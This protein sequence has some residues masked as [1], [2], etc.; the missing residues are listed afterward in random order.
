M[1]NLTPSTE[2][3]GGTPA[4]FRGGKRVFEADT[5]RPVVEAVAAGEVE[6]HAFARRGYPGTRLRKGELEGICTLGYFDAKGR[7]HWGLPFHRN[8]G[9]EFT[10]MLSGEMPMGVNRFRGILKPGHIMITRPWQPHKLGNPCF[11]PGRLLWLIIDVGIRHPHQAWKWPSWIILEPGDLKDL[12]RYLSHNEEPIRRISREMSET[13]ARMC[14]VFGRP[15]EPGFRS[16]VG[17]LINNMLVQLLETYR[18]SN[19]KL[20]SATVSAERTTRIFIN[21]LGD[22]LRNPWTVQTM[23]E[24]CDL[25]V[26]R[27]T[28]YFRQI[29]NETPSH[30][31]GRLRLDRAAKLLTA[32]PE[33]NLN[34]VSR[35]CGFA[36]PNHFIY[37]FKNMYGRSPGKYR[38]NANS[39]G[40]RR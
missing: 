11:V 37:A 23:A 39:Q 32:H 33:F 10:T 3:Q 6:L 22:S 14:D 4:V 9:I 35:E 30:Y 18:S 20:T 40:S 13:F 7:Q 29:T 36:R 15:K 16:K 26:T 31:L 12:T 5:C 34:E 17:V 19:I 27:F 25:G 2:H 1:K 8:E 38:A 24:T 21:N 28:H